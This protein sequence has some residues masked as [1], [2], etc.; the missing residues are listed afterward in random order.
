VG[1]TKWSIIEFLYCKGRKTAI[2]DGFCD[3]DGVPEKL[4]EL[5]DKAEVNLEDIKYLVI[6]HM[7]PDHSG[8]IKDFKKTQHRF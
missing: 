1:D 7:E 8:W 5:L 6:N 3:W 2:I 4:F